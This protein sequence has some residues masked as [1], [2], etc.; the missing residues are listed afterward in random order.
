MQWLNPKTH[1]M[2]NCE[3]VLAFIDLKY[4]K[5]KEDVDDMKTSI[6]EVDMKNGF[7]TY[8]YRANNIFEDLAR[9]WNEDGEPISYD[10]EAIV[11]WMPLPKSP[12]KVKFDNHRLW[13]TKN[14][15]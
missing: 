6:A 8:G 2:P 12:K 7:I 4:H 13:N 15:N 5:N 11:A 10:M 3:D 9:R 14:A 1:E